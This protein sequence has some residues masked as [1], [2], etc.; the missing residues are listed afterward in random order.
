MSISIM[1]SGCYV[2]INGKRKDVQNLGWLLRHWKD[3]VSFETKD[4]GSITGCDLIAHLDNGG[5]YV[6]Q[7]ASRSIMVRWLK[8]PVFIGVKLNGMPITKL[9]V[10]HYIRRKASK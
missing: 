4:N 1:R 6:A 3:V 2:E 7:W 10:K 9:P 5:R 8:R